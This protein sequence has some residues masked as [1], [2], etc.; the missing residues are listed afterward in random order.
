VPMRLP[1]PRFETVERALQ[2]QLV[3]VEKRLE[4]TAQ[5][6]ERGAAARG[7]GWPLGRSG[8]HRFKRWAASNR[9]LPQPNG[10]R[11][12]LRSASVVT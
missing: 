9:E 6:A 2:R 4:R 10:E 1:L 5:A 11:S 12:F 8:R 3:A 7:A